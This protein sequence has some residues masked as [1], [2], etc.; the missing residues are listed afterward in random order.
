MAINGLTKAEFIDALVT[1][2]WEEIPGK[3][4]LIPPDTLFK[5]AP[6]K[7]HVYDAVDLQELLEKP[8]VEKLLMEELDL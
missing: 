5:N 8:F 4:F 6:K 2:G 3:D 1:R 7:F